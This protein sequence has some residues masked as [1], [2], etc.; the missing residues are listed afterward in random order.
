[1]D[2]GY[3]DELFETQ[4]LDVNMVDNEEDPAP[5]TPEMEKKRVAQLSK[6]DFEM[7]L[8]MHMQE[9]ITLPPVTTND[10]IAQ[11]P[12]L[13]ECLDDNHQLDGFY[14]HM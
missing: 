13:V 5:Q 6:R 12:L 2:D 3:E 4:P 14:R 9:K 10:I 7:M 11:V 8:C 1:M